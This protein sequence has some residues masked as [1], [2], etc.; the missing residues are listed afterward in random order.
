[1]L[2]GTS[3]TRI[4]TARLRSTVAF[5]RNVRG[6]ITR[7]E[8]L[9]YDTQFA[10]SIP[11]RLD[12][13]GHLLL[14]VAGTVT[15]ADGR[16][17]A[18][19]VAFV[20]A[21]D[22]LERVGPRSRTFRTH[23]EHV[24]V[25]ILRFARQ[26]LVVPIGLDAGP[27]ALPPSV[28]DDAGRVLQEPASLPVLV[29]TL[30]SARVIRGTVTFQSEEP[31]RFRRLWDAVQPLYQAAGGSVSLKELSVTLGLSMRQVGRDVKELTSTFG[32]GRGYRDTLL[33]LRLRTAV[34]LLSAPGVTINDVAR[35]TGYG[36]AAALAR[37][38]RDARL[39]TPTAVQQALS[40]PRG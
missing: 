26:E 40:S 16:V 27:L 14:V 33:V 18:A 5:E 9:A 13:V 7:R 19:P 34:M 38:F 8:H 1:M 23:G 10:A 28:W 32:F 30:A 12:D 3:D 29:H 36:S 4:A 24:D 15:L 21:D 39:P 22:E 20:L 11:G 31:E 6:T 17:V 25:I 37:A 35:T 2:L